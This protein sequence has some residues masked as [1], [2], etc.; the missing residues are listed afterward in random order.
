MRRFFTMPLA[1]QA[2]VQH[3][4]AFEKKQRAQTPKPGEI[5]ATI[6]LVGYY[7]YNS[8]TKHNDI[9][10]EPPHVPDQINRS[11]GASFP[12][13]LQIA[14][15]IINL[16]PVPGKCVALE[17]GSGWRVKGHIK[18]HGSKEGSE[19][20][21]DK[22]LI[23]AFTQGYSGSFPVSDYVHVKKGRPAQGDDPGEPDSVC[24]INEKWCIVTRNSTWKF[25][26]Q[27]SLNNEFRQL[28]D[29]G[30]TFKIRPRTHITFNLNKLEY[31]VRLGDP[32]DKD[33]VSEA[34]AAPSVFMS[35]ASKFPSIA[36]DHDPSL[37]ES[38]LI[39]VQ[40]DRNAHVLLPISQIKPG[41]P[42]NIYLYVDEYKSPSPAPCG[43]IMKRTVSELQEDFVNIKKE[44]TPEEKRTAHL[45]LLLQAYY[46]RGSEDD[47]AYQL[48]T[49]KLEC[50]GDQVQ[51]AWMI[52]ELKHY[53]ALA[54]ANQDIP[55]HV[56]A[57]VWT[58]SML[59]D[60]DNTEAGLAKM[61]KSDPAMANAAGFYQMSANSMVLDLPRYFVTSGLRI[62]AA[63][64]Q[65]EFGRAINYDGKGQISSIILKPV[66]VAGYV[67][68]PVKQSLGAAVIAL[69][70]GQIDDPKKKPKPTALFHAFDGDVWT[71]MDSC[72]FFYI[73]SRPPADADEVAKY[74]GLYSA[75][76]TQDERDAHFAAMV[77][78]HTHHYWIY[79]VKRS[80]LAIAAKAIGETRSVSPEDPLPTAPAE[81][82]ADASGEKRERET[83]PEDAS[84]QL[85][86]AI[87][88]KKAARKG[89]AK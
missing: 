81:T 46:W 70:N 68:V 72:E 67:Y 47:P 8:A 85:P 56:D 84:T 40:E 65:Q 35:F 32:D 5:Q 74:H 59:I 76:A 29:D 3:A 77:E 63:A 15:R 69:G 60:P 14:G 44:G 50:R 10:S 16:T 33:K 66:A 25:K 48:Y 4:A 64:V 28:E 43:Q 41:T 7:Q 38:E 78:P 11:T 1:M 39:H 18:Y 6:M 20:A 30:V 34:G 22:W 36:G 42:M 51:Q 54:M 88:P 57:N 71:L 27:N 31:Y 58:A 13:Q 19:G 26:T 23:D 73:T 53:Q 49:I 79:A 75:T 86:P 83:E 82:A 61:R 80:A 37:P 12:G 9:L 21:A 89:S 2:S 45:R 87:A 55:I 17:D 52:H 24:A 62:S